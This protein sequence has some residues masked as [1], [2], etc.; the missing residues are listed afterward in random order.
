VGVAIFEQLAVV[1]KDYERDVEYNAFTVFEHKSLS[2]QLIDELREKTLSA[3]AVPVIY[4]I[5][6]SASLNSDIAV[7][8][9]DKLQKNM[10]SFLIDESEAEDF[11]S[12]K[13]KDFSNT[14]DINLKTWYLHPYRQF[15]ELVNESVNLE[16]KIVSGNVKLETTGTSRKDR[17]TSCSYGNYFA[18]LLESE[19]LKE[20]DDN[21]LANFANFARKINNGMGNNSLSKI[22]R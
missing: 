16:Y 4:P 12:K 8:F 11:L 7:D 1:T 13:N 22:F 14:E 19:L 17:Y 5:S 9:R 21:G 2:R 6:A 3:N 20:K 18:S 10:I 15:S